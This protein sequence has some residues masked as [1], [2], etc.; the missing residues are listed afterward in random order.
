MTLEDIEAVIEAFAEGTKRA[1]R[2][3]FQV[4]ELHMAHGYL[5]HQFLSPISNRRTDQYGGSLA[6]RMRLPL[7]VA[8]AV[9]AVIPDELPLLVRL[10][11]TDW[12]EPQ[13]GPSWNPYQSLDLVRG[14]ATRGSVDLVDVSGGGTLARPPPAALNCPGYQ[15]PMS[16]LIR[17]GTGVPTG[18]VGLITEP[19]SA[20]DILREGAAD[21]IFLGR[22]MLREPHWPLRAA[23]ELGLAEVRCPPQYARAIR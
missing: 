5:L 23:K 17:S 11:V 18:A 16:E 7:Q 6:N 13:D 20:E 10:S 19:Q 4:I 12:A 21:A 1:L 9:R 15:V 8:E 22:V 3:G 14:L 2:A